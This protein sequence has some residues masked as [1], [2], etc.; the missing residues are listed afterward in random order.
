VSPKQAFLDSIA[1]GALFFSLWASAFM[2]HG[3]LDVVWN[4]L[5]CV[6][7]ATLYAYLIWWVL[8]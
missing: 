2:L 8:P 3:R 7:F 4:M 1:V 5:R 6:P